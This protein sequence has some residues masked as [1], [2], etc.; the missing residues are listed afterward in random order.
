[1]T[2][3]ASPPTMLALV[4]LRDTPRSRDMQVASVYE[5]SQ[6]LTRPSISA[7]PTGLLSER[8]THALYVS[9][10]ACEHIQVELQEP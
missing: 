4:W 5:M 1:M 7:P 2:M 3:Q 10:V 8:N 9:E 6:L